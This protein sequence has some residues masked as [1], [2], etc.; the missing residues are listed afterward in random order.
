M[1]VTGFALSVVSDTSLFVTCIQCFN[2]VVKGKSFSEDYEQL[3]TLLSLQRTRFSLWGES[4]GLIPDPYSRKNGYDANLDRLNI[5]PLVESTLNN[6]RLLLQKV[7]QVGDKYTHESPVSLSK[8]LPS[9]G[10]H[11]LEVFRT[12]FDRFKSQIKKNQKEASPWKVTQWAIH[13]ETKLRV[14]IDR[15]REYV[16]GLESIT[17]S[18]GLLADQRTRL[19]DEIENISDVERLKLLHDAN[20]SQLA[21]AQLESRT[22]PA[23]VSLQSRNRSSSKRC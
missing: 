13:D 17:K 5:R 20:S 15:L 8:K 2:I 22:L 4:V 14:T 16:D 18:L 6:I 12:P 23:D 10:P 1:E 7:E 11:G 3:Y 19:N 21:S 9:P